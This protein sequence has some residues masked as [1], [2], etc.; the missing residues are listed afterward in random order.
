MTRLLNSLSRLWRRE[1]GT[2][3]IEFVI[4]FPMFFSIMISSIEMGVILTRQVMLDRAVD[5]A[6]RNM[7]LGVYPNVT[8]AVLKE[9]ICEKASVIPNCESEMMLELQS[10]QAPSYTMPSASATCVDRS[11]TMDPI[12]T[13]RDGPENELMI[14]RVCALIDPLFPGTGLGLSITAN[15]TNGFALV[16]TSAYVNEPGAGTSNEGG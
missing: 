8:H 9:A 15:T 13:F 16:S 1:D 14:L 2:A 3:S 6:V 10:I 7:R 12:V 5:L 11:A 4:L